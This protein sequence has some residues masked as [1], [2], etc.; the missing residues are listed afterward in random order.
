[1]ELSCNKIQTTPN[2]ASGRALRSRLDQLR[3][4]HCPSLR[5]LV[6]EEIG[7][8]LPSQ[9]PP[10]ST[11]NST[12]PSTDQPPG[13]EMAQQQQQQVEQISKPL[14]KCDLELIPDYNGNP[15]ELVSF[16]DVVE[17]LCDNYCT[18]GITE[19]A[20]NHWR[21]LHTIKNKLHGTAKLAV[22]NSACETV[23]EIV[24]I[25]K[26]NFADNRSVHQL[27]AE[28][29]ALRPNSKFH[30]LIFVNTLEEKRTTIIS[31]HKLDGVQGNFLQFV[32]DQL[33][34]QIIN[35][36]VDS[37]PYQL[38]AHLQTL[39]ISNLHEARQAII[40]QSSSI[41]KHLGFTTDVSKMH[42]KNFS[43]DFHHKSFQNAPP[44]KQ[45]HNPPFQQR[46]HQGQFKHN[47]QPN[48]PYNDQNRNT[49]NHSHD[50]SM[51][52]VS[53]LRKPNSVHLTENFES[54][55]V[56]KLEEKIE[57]LTDAFQHFLE[58]G[59]SRNSPT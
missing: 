35:V 8:V 42:H 28:L 54:S 56:E 32:I 20:I 40:N 50:V 39:K 27:T 31:R 29:L 7:V 44:P 51:R 34:K 25:L 18:V 13:D 37:L 43:N 11:S 45:F 3:L 26:N 2:L 36:L 55:R 21:L 5:E 46:P 52:T 48:R 17:T 14:Q 1:V 49:N 4:Q 58:L 57:K 10:S 22:F 59:H 33:D 38:G 23:R 15:I 47:S 19:A 16:L 12:P 41:L 30:P 24:T 53:N 6:N 9:P